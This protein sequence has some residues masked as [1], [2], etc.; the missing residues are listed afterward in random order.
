M[1]EER[2]I[3]RDNKEKL[4]DLLNF[5]A[6]LEIEVKINKKSCNG[7]PFVPTKKQI[8]EEIN[9]VNQTEVIGTDT[10]DIEVKNDV[11]NIEN[12]TEEIIETDMEV[13]NDVSN[14]EN[15]TDEMI[16]T[17]IEEI[18]EKIDITK[19]EIITEEIGT[20]TE[21]FGTESEDI[22]QPDN[23]NSNDQAKVVE[24]EEIKVNTVEKR[25]HQ[26]TLKRMIMLK[27]HQKGYHMLNE[28]NLG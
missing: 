27:T 28:K 1:I 11:T 8:P 18:E 21:P 6:T 24:T 4:K 12:I 25:S 17:D 22:S 2:K 3:N 15:I 7:K 16:K 23:L 19:I 14:V 5:M 26:M 9:T 13:K 10:K 20:Q